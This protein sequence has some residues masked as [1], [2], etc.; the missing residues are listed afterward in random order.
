MTSRVQKFTIEPPPVDEMIDEDSGEEEDGSTVEK[1][2]GRQL[3]ATVTAAVL[4]H[5]V[6]STITCDQQYVISDESIVFLE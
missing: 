6:H 3:R 5:R 4:R 1:L 2:S